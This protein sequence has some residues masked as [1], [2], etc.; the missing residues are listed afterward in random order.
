[1]KSFLS[2]ARLSLLIGFHYLNRHK[3]FFLLTII[4]L[5]A[6]VFAQVK[7]NLLFQ[8]NAVRIGIIGTYQEHDLPLSVTELLSDGLVEADKG[9]NIKPK[10]VTGWEVNNDATIFKFKLRDGLFWADGTKVSARDLNFNIPDVDVSYPEDNVIQFKLRDSYSPFPSLLTKPIFKT[11]TLLGTGPYRVTRVEKSEIFITKIIL[12]PNNKNLPQVYIRFYPNENVAMTGFN[13]GEV[14]VLMGVSSADFAKQNPKVRFLA[15]TDYNKI[16]TLLYNTKDPVL[17]SRSFR[18]AL[19]F[20]APQIQGFEVAD[21]PF[22]ETSWAYDPSSKKYL[23]DLSD[24][25]SAMERAKSSVDA[26]K[27]KEGLTVTAIPNLEGVAKQ[28]ATAWKSL[29]VD[30][31][32]RVESGIPQNF[33]ILLITQSIPSDPDQYFLWHSTQSTSN[34][35][36]YSSPRVDKDLE[37]GRKTTNQEDRKAKYFDFQKA[38]LEDSPATFLYFPKYNIVYLSKVEKTLQKILPLE[39]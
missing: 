10:L 33:Q 15:S 4:I 14:S 6:L 28:I 29:G 26:D 18:Q 1:M 24:A 7:F 9:G 8:T 16:V 36:K 22:P 12:E 35:S 39:K 17:S 25:K 5:A 19:S 34:L 2:T 32:V 20:V 13:L 21:N 11:G 38:L 3:Q 37:D 27:L 31:K 30:V 23:N